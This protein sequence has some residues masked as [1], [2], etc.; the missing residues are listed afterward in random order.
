MA[1]DPRE[2]QVI[3]NMHIDENG[4]A[5]TRRGSRLLS[6]TALNGAVTAIYDFRRPNGAEYTNEWIVKAGKYLYSVNTDTYVATVITDLDTTTRP[7]FCTFQDENSISYVFIADGSNFLKWDGETLTSVASSY[8]WAFGAP[9][10]I[11]VYDDRM[12]AAGLD[13]DPYKVFVS[14]S[15]D[16]T[17]WFPGTSTTAVYW[18]LKSP[19]GDRVMGLSQVYDYGVI[20][21]QFGVTIITEADP[22]SDTSAQIQVSREYGT[23]SHQSIQSIG[24]T[25][26]FADRDHIYKGV[27][28]EA[29]ENGL[30]IVPI[31]KNIYE[32]Y[33]ESIDPFNVVSVYDSA[34]KEIQWGFRTGLST[35]HNISI[36]YNVGLSKAAERDVWSGWFESDGYEPYT[37]ASGIRRYTAHY[38]D[39]TQYTAEKYVVL[40][41]DEDGFVYIMDDDTKYKDDTYESSATVENAIVSEIYTAVIAPHGTTV[42]KRA[43]DVTMIVY[44]NYNDST[45]V[46]FIIDGR[47]LSTERTLSLKNI[48]PMWNDGTDTNQKQL[49][50]NTIWAERPVLVKPIAMNTPFQ[51]LQAIITNAGSNAKDEISYSGIELYYQLH[52]IRR[53]V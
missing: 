24:N 20:F 12:L 10:Y 25:L 22:E 43:R 33:S 47:K 44:S 48:V 14:A 17:D 1:L 6:T 39:G 38:G 3:R 27:L 51:Y 49:W 29:I 11:F 46:Q 32:K 8:P 5:R 34:N 52:N 36:V 26:Y 50:N 9:R 30:E 23:T 40:R 31:D 4:I 21:Q 42:V 41:G 53:N 2:A 28:R 35:R 7:T 15:L 13:S 45:T 37:L 18:T 19:S 16:G